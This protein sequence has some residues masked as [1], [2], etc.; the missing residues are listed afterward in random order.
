MY[1]TW[2]ASSV[3]GQHA[4][5]AHEGKSRTMSMHAD[6]ESDSRI[7]PKKPRTM[8]SNIGGGDGGGKAA[9]QGEGPLRRMLRTQRRDPHV[10]E[11]A[12]S[13][14]GATWVPNT[15]NTDHV[16][17]ETGAGCG[18]AACPDLHGGRGAILVPTV[19]IARPGTSRC[20]NC[21]RAS[22]RHLILWHP[23]RSGASC[24]AA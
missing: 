2:E 22:A 4:G 9:G 6:E 18:K 1:G 13:R 19:T 14:I 16:R 20:S 11:A 24:E 8:S 5:P 12:C 7:V 21:F 23:R 17:P 15:P 3:S 10:T